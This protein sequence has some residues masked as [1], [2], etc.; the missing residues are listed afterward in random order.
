MTVLIGVR[1]HRTII[2]PNDAEVRADFFGLELTVPLSSHNRQCT[3]W[4]QVRR[5]AEIDV[6]FYDVHF[7]A[8]LLTSKI[9][10]FLKNSILTR[11][12]K[13][14]KIIWTAKC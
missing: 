3:A 10:N 4:C 5:R 8:A 9:R 14:A 12:L 2:A 13:F 6:S 11:L 7:V 1:I